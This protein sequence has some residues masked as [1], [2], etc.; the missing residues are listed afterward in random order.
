M[1]RF[2][3]TDSVKME[4]EI[5]PALDFAIPRLHLRRDAHKPK[6]KILLLFSE[7]SGALGWILLRLRS[8]SP[9]HH[10]EVRKCV[11]ILLTS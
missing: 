3:S 1:V 4:K 11:H 7:L 6:A 8:H 2:S 10:E 9:V 5:I